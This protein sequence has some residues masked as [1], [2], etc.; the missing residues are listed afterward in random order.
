MVLNIKTLRVQKY[1]VLT[2]VIA[3]LVTL[4]YWIDK[5][6][7][8]QSNPAIVISVNNNTECDLLSSPCTYIIENKKIRLEF[9]TKVRTLKSFKLKAKLFGFKSSIKKIKSDFSMKSMS[10]GLNSFQFKRV[11]LEESTS[12][13]LS[14]ILLPICT[15][16]R[17]DWTMLVEIETENNIYQL[18]LPLMIE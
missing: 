10:M 12:S 13:W 16:Q 9:L 2:I 8:Q 5:F 11:A 15:S 7:F 1:L 18:S 17:T 3:I 6:N 4:Y 14:T